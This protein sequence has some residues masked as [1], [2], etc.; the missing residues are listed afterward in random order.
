MNRVLLAALPCAAW[1][2]SAVAVAGPP[3]PQAGTDVTAPAFTAFDSDAS[4]DVTQTINPLVV[5]FKA[6]DDL[7]GVSFGGAKAY[8][9]S[10]QMVEVNFSRSAPS[11]NA[12][13]VM[14]S[15][16]VSA[17]ME[18]GTYVF[19]SAY[20]GDENYNYA[21]YDET[22]LAALGRS[23]FTV[24][25]HKGYD[26][27]A[28]NLVSGKLKTPTISVSSHHPGTNV[29]P[30]AQVSLQASDSGNTAI[31]GVRDATAMFCTAGR[32]QCFSV[33]SFDDLAP[34]DAAARL[35][36]GEQIQSY[37]APGTYVLYQ[38]SMSDYAGNRQ[39]LTSQVFGGTT[40][41]SLYFPS[42]AITLTP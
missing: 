1:L 15:Y 11:T 24:K 41:F 37:Q 23:T 36:L 16:H 20:L 32:A 38:V 3:S 10:G 31:A 21:Q 42:T 27:V 8:G 12:S 9:P 19:K 18:P 33:Y 34:Q 39:T 29:A 6:T 35:T 5:R 2:T 7:S 26:I 28:P 30:Y 13:G 14:L 4:V 25:N 17:F 22:A 40:D